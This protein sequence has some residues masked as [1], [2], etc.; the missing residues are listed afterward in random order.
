MS[1]GW[2]ERALSCEELFIDIL[3]SL[4]MHPLVA[5]PTPPK[6]LIAQFSQMES[7]QCLG[8]PLACCRRD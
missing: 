2:Y 8:L 7:R 3:T 5:P 6:T 1:I 4:N